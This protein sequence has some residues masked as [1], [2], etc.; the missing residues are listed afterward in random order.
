[1]INRRPHSVGSCRDFSR[2]VEMRN[3]T[4]RPIPD[5]RTLELAR[6]VRRKHMKCPCLSVA[7][8]VLTAE[9]I[10]SKVVV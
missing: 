1:L 7:Q 6:T 2:V 8:A 3:Q 9:N 5:I 10:F 4:R